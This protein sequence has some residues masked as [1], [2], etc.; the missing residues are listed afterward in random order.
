MKKKLSLIGFFLLIVTSIALLCSFAIAFLM[1]QKKKNPSIKL[2]T[3]YIKQLEPFA[4][5]VV[6]F[7]D[8][9]T[10]ESYIITNIEDNSTN[11]IEI[12]FINKN[13]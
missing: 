4:T 9:N 8:E 13:K 5:K 10:K 3:N 6:Y 1:P 12:N 2:L 11:I 7:S